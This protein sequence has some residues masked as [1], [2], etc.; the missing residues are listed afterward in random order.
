MGIFSIFK[1][2]KSE[3]SSERSSRSLVKSSK[4]PTKS[5]FIEHHAKKFIVMTKKTTSNVKANVSF[6]ANHQQKRLPL[7]DQGYVRK[8]AYEPGSKS[9]EYAIAR[10]KRDGYSVVVA[11]GKNGYGET[12]SFLL[13][14]PGGRASATT[15]TVT[16]RKVKAKAPAKKVKKVT[17]PATIEVSGK[18]YRKEATYRGYKESASGYARARAKD[19][20][21]ARVKKFV[22]NG[23]AVYAV[24]TAKKKQP[25][26]EFVA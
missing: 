4:K 26:Y 18:R 16:P 10:L 21:S 22:I 8:G 17:I 5:G 2:K 23:D 13:A 19:G 14:R 7:E 24:Y 9:L 20:Y 1:Q 12:Q 3:K 25:K 6:A 15:K 11:T